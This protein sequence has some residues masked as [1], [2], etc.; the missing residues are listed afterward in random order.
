MTVLRHVALLWC[1]CVVSTGWAQ[2]SESV[3]DRLR[4]S[5]TAAAASLFLEPDRAFSITVERKVPG[6]VHLRWDI[7][8][9][10]Y[11][12]QDKFQLSQGAYHHD[13]KVLLPE[14]MA[15]YDELFG[16]V[17]VYYRELVLDV[18][19]FGER[20][21]YLRYQGC[22]EDSICYPPISKRF[23]L[24]GSAVGS[25]PLSGLP[26]AAPPAV[27]ASLS[28]PARSP[29]PA[30]AP[31]PAQ[32]DV[33][34]LAP[35]TEQD[36]ITRSLAE[37]R[38][39]AIM[40][41]FFGLG[42]LLSLT[43]CIYPMIPILASTI[44]RHGGRMATGRAFMLS[45]SFVLAMAISYAVF[46]AIAGL[47]HFNLQT[48]SQKPWVIAL[49]ST[50]FVWLALATFGLFN[51]QLPSAL[52]NRL[53]RIGARQKTGS[54]SGAA[55]MGALSALI[56]GPCV[57]PPL[58]G[59]L[60]YISQTGDAV[61]GGLALFMLGMGLGVPLLVIGSSAGALLPKAGKWM[62]TVKRFFGV[63][64]LA[65][66][67]GLLE[68][69][70][71][72]TLS[73]GLWSI[74]LIGTAVGMGA[75][76]R[77][78]ATSA[79][80]WTRLRTGTGLAMLCYGAILMLG[81][82]TGGG[83]LQEPLRGWQSDTSSARLEKP[84][85]H[86]SDPASLQLALSE[87]KQRKEPVVLYFYAD[88]CTSCAEMARTTFADS[89]VRALLRRTVALRQD[90]SHGN[91]EDLRLLQKFSLFGP[92]GLVFFDRSGQEIRAWRQ[93]GRIDA[94]TLTRYLQALLQVGSS[95]LLRPLQG[96]IRAAAG[97]AERMPG[98]MQ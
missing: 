42:L 65:V 45:L 5:G 83:T 86:L 51:L 37:G 62:N 94:E 64:L 1:L 31:P 15:K 9:G 16:E 92:P 68:R 48:A 56:V 81:A 57:T 19:L 23:I 22:K 53:Q 78:D 80:V 82:A 29:P 6:R 50:V 4:A 55:A 77:L 39:L 27:A 52:Q 33:S 28:L 41:T 72:D 75:M 87:A 34:V 97:S 43:P 35:L 11:L 60:L 7:A 91:A 32:G 71:P 96:T 88:W 24:V 2:Q 73:A 21:L 38:P 3:L 54:L 84:F 14:G 89:G 90:L 70:L 18:P 30:L 76:D 12:Y 17:Q 13:M 36:R 46:G 93:V 85:R 69:I 25:G 10:Y 59:A 49:F 44:A 63:L 20:P 47:F 67:I 8:P 95:D 26:T 74:L 66:A 40:L 58:I 98:K 61:W 79:S